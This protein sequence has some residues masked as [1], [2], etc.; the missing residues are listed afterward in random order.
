MRSLC[1]LLKENDL[2]I[3]KELPFRGVQVYDF[4][5]NT[6]AIVYYDF[7]YKTNQ[8]SIVRYK[9][10]YKDTTNVNV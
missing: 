1:N 3:V 9:P 7:S 6:L 4:V 2:V 5:L 8:Y 10:I